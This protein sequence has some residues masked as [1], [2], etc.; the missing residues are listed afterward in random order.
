LATRG[1]LVNSRQC[2][3]RPRNVQ[4]RIMHRASAEHDHCEWRCPNYDQCNFRR[5]LRHDSFFSGSHLTLQQIVE[6]I[7]HWSRNHKESEV[8]DEI[9]IADHTVVD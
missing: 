6:L 1:L 8:K 2:E 4:C 5:S 7:Y 9:D 3:V